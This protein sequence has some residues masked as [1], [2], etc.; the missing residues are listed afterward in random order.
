MAKARKAQTT[1]AG[2]EQFMLKERVAGYYELITA[3]NMDD[4][5]LTAVSSLPQVK[6]ADRFGHVNGFI[7]INPLYTPVE[8]DEAI[9]KLVTE[10]TERVLGRTAYTREGCNFKRV[11]TDYIYVYYQAYVDEARVERL[12]THLEQHEGVSN[13]LNS[14]FDVRHF[15]V[16]FHRAYNP[17]EAYVRVTNIIRHALDDGCDCFEE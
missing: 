13:V 9:T 7:S 16:S 14:K 5:F 3:T 10:M 2:H 4:T 11:Q 1:R 17:D 8:L 6:N 15:S 12:V